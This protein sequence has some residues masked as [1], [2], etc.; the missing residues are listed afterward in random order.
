[1]ELGLSA[2]NTDRMTPRRHLFVRL[3]VTVNIVLQR[4][5]MGDTQR[6]KRADVEDHDVAR[7]AEVESGLIIS[8]GGYCSEWEASS[9]SVP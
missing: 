2:D 3:Q 1:M 7:G 9:R 5:R 6:C 8:P 4:G